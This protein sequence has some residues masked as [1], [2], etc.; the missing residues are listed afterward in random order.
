MTLY[1][2]LTIYNQCVWLLRSIIENDTK[3]STYIGKYLHLYADID[4]S[5]KNRDNIKVLQKKYEVYL[6]ALNDTYNHLTSANCMLFSRMNYFKMIYPSKTFQEPLV[7]DIM[8]MV[9]QSIDYGQYQIIYVFETLNMR[10]LEL[11]YLITPPTDKNRQHLLDNIKSVE[12]IIEKL[13]SKLSVMR[14]SFHLLLSSKFEETI[15]KLVP[16]LKPSLDKE[17][18]QKPKLIEKKSTKKP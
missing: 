9:Q 17:E 16:Y 14:D 6:D 5:I 1:S 18:I 11:R 3:T 15:K 12:D 2:E 4:N 10:D 8:L 7:N 13:F